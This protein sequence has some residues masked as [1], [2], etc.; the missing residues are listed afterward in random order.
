M[1]QLGIEQVLSELGASIGADLKPDANGVVTLAI[2]DDVALSIEVPADSDFVYFHGSVKRLGGSDRVAALE[3]AMERN[4]FGLSMSG[5]WL[6]LDR[7]SGELLLCYSSL[8]AGV[9]ADKLLGTL[10]ALAATVRALR[11]EE[12]GQRGDDNTQSLSVTDHF[13]RV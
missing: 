4:L 12:S 13:I 2:G 10:E 8:A 3:D 7:S 9:D 1:T 11:Q 6:A 5:A